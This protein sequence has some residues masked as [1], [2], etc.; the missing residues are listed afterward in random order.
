L[1][2]FCGLIVRYRFLTSCCW[3]PEAARGWVVAASPP[4]SSDVSSPPPAPESEGVILGGVA[5][6]AVRPVV[7]CI[8]PLIALGGFVVS[9]GSLI[10]GALQED[11]FS[12]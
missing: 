9:A 3:L 2:S 12:C 4:S 10:V 6:C 5:L 1:G 7:V 11:W 8:V